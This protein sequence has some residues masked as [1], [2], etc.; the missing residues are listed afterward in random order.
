MD[1]THVDAWKEEQLHKLKEEI[2]DRTQ[3]TDET[4]WDNF[5]E[6][7]KNAFVNQNR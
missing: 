7:F 5:L 2:D 3:E 4:L 6:R 1:G